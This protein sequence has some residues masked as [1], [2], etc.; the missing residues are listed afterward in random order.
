MPL[1]VARP[2]SSTGIG[3][4]GVADPEDGVRPAQQAQHPGKCFRDSGAGGTPTH[5]QRI[6]RTLPVSGVQHRL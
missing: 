3:S 4:T 5:G 6:M 2:N 1:G